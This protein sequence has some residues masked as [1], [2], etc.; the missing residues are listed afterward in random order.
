MEALLAATESWE[1]IHYLVYLKLA[2][3]HKKMMKT[4][5]H[6]SL[7]PSNLIQLTT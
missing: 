5:S 2:S 1:E 7:M 4:I 6:F 3:A